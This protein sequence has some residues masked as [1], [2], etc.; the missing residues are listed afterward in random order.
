[1]KNKL[2]K[3]QMIAIKKEEKAKKKKEVE[4]IINHHIN[5]SMVIIDNAYNNIINSMEKA[6]EDLLDVVN[7]LNNRK[8]ALRTC[9]KDNDLVKASIITIDTFDLVSTISKDHLLFTRPAK[10]NDIV[11]PLTKAGKDVVDYVTNEFHNGSLKKHPSRNSIV[12]RIAYAINT[13]TNEYSKMICDEFY[14]NNPYEQFFCAAFKE[15]CE[16]AFSIEEYLIEIEEANEIK[17]NSNTKENNNING[18]LRITY[19]D[20]MDFARHMGFE[21]VRQSASTHRIWKNPDTGISLPIPANKGRILPQG[22][23]SRMLKQMGL[24]RNDL[25][26][27]ISSK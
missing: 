12:S 20:M 18:R 5:K 24:K 2:S 6:N 17:Q 9:I 4:G 14:K 16:I 26:E 19:N 22:T 15:F 23:M 25:A 27:F 7:I 8:I 13:K 21:E 3:K 10:A 1:M 11:E